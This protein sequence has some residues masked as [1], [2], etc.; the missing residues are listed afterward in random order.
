MNQPNGL[1]EVLLDLNADIASRDDAAM[2]LGLFDN[3]EAEKALFEVASNKETDEM[4]SSSAGESLA[5][6]WIRRKCINKEYFL[7]L[8]VTA[9]HEAEA[10]IN[11]NLPELLNS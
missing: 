2:D 4:V 6:I 9:K 3:I 1:I 5:Q 10:T 8:S 11:A 7:S